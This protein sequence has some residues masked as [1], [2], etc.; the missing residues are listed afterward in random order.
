MPRLSCVPLSLLIAVTPETQPSI[1]TSR[2]VSRAQGPEQGALTQTYPEEPLSGLR[3]AQVPVPG[4]D[5]SA[6]FQ[7]LPVVN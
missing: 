1:A 5:P 3:S 4:Q 2:A 6:W 7:I